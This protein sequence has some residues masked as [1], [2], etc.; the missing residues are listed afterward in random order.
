MSEGWM[1]WVRVFRL[2]LSVE[3]MFLSTPTEKI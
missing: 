1:R 2:G 3:N